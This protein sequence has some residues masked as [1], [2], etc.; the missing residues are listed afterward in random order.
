MFRAICFLVFLG[1][2]LAEEPL[3]VLVKAAS[4]FSAAIGQQL[5]MLERDPS[6]QEFAEKT[7]GYATAKAA[8]FEAL[9]GG[10]AGTNKKCSPP[11]KV[12]E[13]GRLHCSVC[14]CWRKTA[15]AS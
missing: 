3:D 6:V 11:G 7:T 14:S 5:Q 8:Y 10:N 13:V 2:A 15:S 9:R 4:S 1:S 12:P